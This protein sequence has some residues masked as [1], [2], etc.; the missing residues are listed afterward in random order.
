M[1]LVTGATGFV[2]RYV[3]KKIVSIRDDI[4]IL[5]RH[6]ELATRLYPDAEIF[7]GDITDKNSLKGV[8]KDVDIVIHL[9]GLVS[10][11]KPKDVLYKV[12]IEGTRNILNE[13]KNAKKFIFSSSVS[14]YGEIKGKADEDY[15]RNPKNYYGESKM[16]AEDAITDSGIPYI[17]M[18]IAPIYGK[19]SPSW[20]KNLKLMENNFPI[21]KTS[22]LTHIVHISDIANAFALSLKKNITGVY[23]IADEKPIKFVD[24]SSKLVQLLGKEPKFMPFW[25]VSFLARLKGMKTYFDVLTMNRYYDITKAKTRLGYKPQAD[26]EKELSEMIEWYKKEREAGINLQS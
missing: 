10:Y 5:S 7:K 19:G 13:C 2:G 22:N 8:G 9:A 4:R 26:L 23:N 25:M 20:F 14:V 17:I 12:N 24:L 15:P 16:Y 21:P 1:L 3:M 6:A 11:S 18:R